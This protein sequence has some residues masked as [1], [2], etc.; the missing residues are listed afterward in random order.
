[1]KQRDTTARR[2]QRLATNVLDSRLHKDQQQQQQK[3]QQ[4]EEKSLTAS[5]MKRRTKRQRQYTVELFEQLPE[6]RTRTRKTRESKQTDPKTE[7]IP[8]VPG[9]ELPVQTSQPRTGRGRIKK[10]IQQRATASQL[11]DG[12]DEPKAQSTSRTET[13]KEPKQTKNRR[14][15][16]EETEQL[17]K[18]KSRVKRIIEPIREVSPCPSN[19]RIDE[20]SIVSELEE[21]SDRRLEACRT[22]TPMP[23][24]TASYDDKNITET[25]NVSGLNESEEELIDGATRTRSDKEITHEASVQTESARSDQN[26]AETVTDGTHRRGRSTQRKNDLDVK[27]VCCQNNRPADVRRHETLTTDTPVST[28]V[29]KQSGRARALKSTLSE[30]C[31]ECESGMSPSRGL[32]LADSV[33]QT[34]GHVKQL[35]CHHEKHVDETTR[36]STAPRSVDDAI[37]LPVSCGAGRAQLVLN[38]LETGSR[39]ACVRLSDG[40][41]LTPNEFQLISGRGNAKDWKRSIRHH[42]HSLKSLVEQGLLSL[43]SP[44]LCICEHCDLPVQVSVTCTAKYLPVTLVAVAV[45]VLSAFFFVSC[46]MPF[47]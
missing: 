42:G 47:L 17:L 1:M 25:R 35:S 19:E 32:S 41:W 31:R 6:S 21:Q 22:P 16:T 24:Q 30:K 29:V 34:I 4:D 3:Q 38:R 36:N 28:K 40:S 10:L 7:S 37:V 9:S 14:T 46:K 27:D 8:D 2:S 33:D 15:T 20:T 45:R 12:K 5:V 11:I 39:G 44:P 18:A 43:A 13:T 26:C 23:E